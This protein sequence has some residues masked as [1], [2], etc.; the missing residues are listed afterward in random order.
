MTKNAGAILWPDYDKSILG[1]PNALLRH[2][3]AEA[4]YPSL[5]ALDAL[6]AKGYRNVVLMVFDGMGCDMLR[7]N[8]PEDAFLRRRTAADILSVYPC[9][10]TAA[11]TC[12][13]TGLPPIA[14]GW[15]GWSCYFKELGQCVD[16]YTNQSASNTP[17]A[18]YDV[19]RT[20]MPYTTISEKIAE[21]SPD[22]SVYRVS[23]FSQTHHAATPAE[24]CAQTRAICQSPGRHFV[25]AYCNQ[26]DYTMHEHGCYAENVRQLARHINDEVERLCNTLADTLVIVT[27]DHGLTGTRDMFIEDFPALYDCLQMRPSIESRCL[28]FFIKDGMADVFAARFDEQFGADFILMTK[29]ETLAKHIFGHGTP[30][31]KAL[32]FIGDFIAVATGDIRLAHR[33]SSFPFKAMHAGLRAAEMEVPLILIEKE[34]PV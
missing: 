30:H 5:P 17:A 27:A 32:D 22:V 14:H 11:V 2:Y 25:N 34:W 12:F 20:Y 16:L 26:P 9:T 24:V 13:E 31:P 8:L 21:A 6:L 15:L 10:T 7:Q 4:V 28:S 1:I 19:A 29:A 33:G 23:L 18:D 3:S